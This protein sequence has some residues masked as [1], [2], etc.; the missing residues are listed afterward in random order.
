[1]KT[2]RLLAGLLGCLLAAPAAQWVCACS[3]AAA[4][5]AAST[6]CQTS[7]RQA[8]PRCTAC[9]QSEGADLVRTA[10]QVADHDCPCAHRLAPEQ[11]LPVD[12]GGVPFSGASSSPS[13]SVKSPPA[14]LDRR[15]Q[16]ADSRSAPGLHPPTF[17]LD[18]AFLI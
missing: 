3:P 10:D 4:H 1:M 6:C 2:I 9:Q 15:C 14:G 16:P 5:P 17:L 18:C 12:A 11:E 8:P 13:S 7:Q